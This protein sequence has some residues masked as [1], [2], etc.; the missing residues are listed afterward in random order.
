MRIATRPDAGKRTVSLKLSLEYSEKTGCLNRN[1]A[2][3]PLTIEGKKTVGLEIFAQNNFKVPDAIIVS[4]GDGVI[5]AGVYKAFYDLKEA[6]LINKLP[7]L[8]CVQA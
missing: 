5:I 3:H 6:G 7:K 1:T 8:I 4:V 2:Y